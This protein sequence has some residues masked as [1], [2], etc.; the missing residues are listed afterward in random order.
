MF[1]ASTGLAARHSIIRRS[2]TGPE[3]VEAKRL[4]ALESENA[5]PKKLF[6]DDVLDKA[7]L[8]DLL[9]KNGDACHQARDF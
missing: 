6:A 4:R 1:A 8:K 7:M 5:R 9:S 3:R 2:S